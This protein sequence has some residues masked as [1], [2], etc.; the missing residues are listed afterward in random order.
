[1]LN[2]NVKKFRRSK[3]ILNDHDYTARLTIE[4]LD[5]I[6]VIGVPK[7][8]LLGYTKVEFI[9]NAFNW[10]NTEMFPPKTM[11]ILS[12]EFKKRVGLAKELGLENFDIS[13]NVQFISKDG[14]SVWAYY[15]SY[16]NLADNIVELYIKFLDEF[17]SI[18]TSIKN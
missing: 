10:L 3:R 6:E 12:D 1:M 15:V 8:G 2:E 17:T 16:Y 7:D 18:D 5:L 11:A 4:P 13:M 9:K 14:Q